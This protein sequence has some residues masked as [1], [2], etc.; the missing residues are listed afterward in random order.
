MFFNLLLADKSTKKCFPM[1]SQTT[2]IAFCKYEQIW[3]LMA[4][5]HPKKLGQRPNK[6]E[7]IIQI[8]LCNYFETVHNEQVNW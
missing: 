3:I 2:F 4:A 6:S 5:T 8:K 7:K 1:F